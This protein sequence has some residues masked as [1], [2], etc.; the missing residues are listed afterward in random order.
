MENPVPKML[1]VQDKE[2]IDISK[3]ASY[4][5]LDQP[6]TRI[7]TKNNATPL[8]PHR[9]RVRERGLPYLDWILSIE[10]DSN[11]RFIDKIF[12]LFC[13]TNFTYVRT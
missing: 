10:L 4:M 8:D 9:I 11:N 5:I 2:R 13:M 1:K 12:N 3:M 7:I 6:G